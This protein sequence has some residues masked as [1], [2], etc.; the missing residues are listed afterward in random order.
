MNFNIISDNSKNKV[1]LEINES[2]NCLDNTYSINMA[3]E[4]AKLDITL[5]DE[6]IES[7]KTL[8]ADCDTIDY[9]LAASSGA[10]CGILDIFLIGKPGESPLENITDKWFANRTMDFAKIM[11]WNPKGESKLENAIAWL[12]RRFKIPYDQTSLGE[13]AKSVFG[14]NT[15]PSRHHFESLGHNPSILGLFFSILDQFTNS[16]HFV[17]DGQLI[18][19]VEADEKF[20]LRGSNIISKLFCG[21]CNWFGH[22]MSDISGSHGS[23][24]R[25][26]RGMGIPSPLWTWINDIIV[27]KR[28]LG[29][30]ESEFDKSMNQ[31]AVDIFNEGYDIR[32]QT[33]QG[34]PVL[35]NELI[36]RFFYAIRR[37][38]KYY[39][40]TRKEKRSVKE[41]WNTCKPFGNATIKRMLTVA[42]GTFCLVDVADATVRGFAAGGGSFNPV[43]FFLHLNLI[44]V[45]RLTISLYGE[46]KREFNYHKAQ[47]EVQFTQEKK[48]IIKNYIEGLESLKVLYDDKEYLSFIEDLSKNEYINALIK[49]SD[50]A[51]RRGVPDSQ[52]L[53]TPKDIDNYF[54]SKNKR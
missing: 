47:K 11:G 23:A 20:K 53:K 39:N 50:L 16:S 33:A 48:E 3:L 21:I 30:S 37:L 52:I 38:L 44:G 42:H 18:S 19:L 6:T 40:E 4:Q 10:L 5:L 13:A 27:I 51:V 36:V 1:L 7:V 35:I 31:I 24:F 17:I 28:K 2:K 15:D 32:F 29:I 8:K 26:S 14:F 46:G 12:E 45:G 49:S 25:A 34:I 41:M 22:L 9:V 43:K 54:N